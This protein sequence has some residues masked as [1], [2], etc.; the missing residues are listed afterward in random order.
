MLISLVGKFYSLIVLVISTV[1]SPIES[2]TSWKWWGVKGSMDFN[3]LQYTRE[4]SPRYVLLHSPFPDHTTI[5]KGATAFYFPW[6]FHRSSLSQLFVG[7]SIYLVNVQIIGGPAYLFGLT[8][9]LTFK[10][11]EQVSSFHLLQKNK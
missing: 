10:K 1:C 6:C 11:S 7:Y 4:S 3:F 5:S 8:L 2:W 9:K